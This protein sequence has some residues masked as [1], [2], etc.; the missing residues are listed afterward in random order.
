MRVF[1]TGGTGAI[2]GHAVPA[3]VGE[4]HTVTVLARTP[5]KATA[6]AK[7]GARPVTASIF[8]RSEL[9]ATARLS[10]SA[11]HGRR[12]TWNRDPRLGVVRP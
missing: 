2:G 4:G 10:I 1:V 8:D 11:S 7:R 5:E 9:T 3:I 12:R 6:L